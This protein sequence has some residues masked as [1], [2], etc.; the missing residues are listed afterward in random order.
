L[1]LKLYYLKLREAGLQKDVFDNAQNIITAKN[2]PQ[3]YAAAGLKRSHNPSQS[4]FNNTLKK[5][6]PNAEFNQW[7][8]INDA[9]TLK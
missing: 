6:H 7:G 9:A 4:V 1:Q 8:N 3:P 2:R 5:W